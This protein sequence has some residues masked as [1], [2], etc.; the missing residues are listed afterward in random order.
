MLKIKEQ[1]KPYIYESGGHYPPPN[2]V[3][4]R[5]PNIAPSFNQPEIIHTAKNVPVIKYLAYSFLTL[6]A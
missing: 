2:I 4:G 6:V 1:I 3:L 5:P